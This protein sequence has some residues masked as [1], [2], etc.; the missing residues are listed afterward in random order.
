MARS[1]LAQ[2]VAVV[3]LGVPVAAAAVYW[4][5]W[6]LGVALAAV[7]AGGAFELYRLAGLR[8]VR[9]FVLPGVL[10]AGLLVLIATSRPW[11]L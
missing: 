6:V 5:G 9:L 10:A 2:R 3:L 4:G 7:A 11:W 1:E 8:G